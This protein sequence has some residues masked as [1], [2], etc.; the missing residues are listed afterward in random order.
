M[1]KLTFTEAATCNLN[2]KA[3]VT[4]EKSEKMQRAW[5][6]AGK[7]WLSGAKDVCSKSI[8]YLFLD[9][10]LSLGHGDFNSVKDCN[11]EE[12]E[13]IDDLPQHDFSNQQDVWLWLAQGNQI[14]EIATGD[15][16][17]F[18]DNVLWRNSDMSKYNFADFL[19]WKK[20]TPPRLIRVNGV[21]VPAPLESLDG[22]EYVWVAMPT[23]QNKYSYVKTSFLAECCRDFSYGNKED[24]I[25]RAEAMEKFEVVE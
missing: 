2:L 19:D 9:D 14:K 3:R 16:V 5:F 18:K 10:K 12:I 13:L 15:I 22:F 25:K 21:E 24:A 4:P 8:G 6:A 11:Y 23:H 17:R 7:T 20:H 1:R